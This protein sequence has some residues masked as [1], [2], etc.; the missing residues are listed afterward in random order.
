[1][2]EG[3]RFAPASTIGTEFELLSIRCSRLP[4]TSAS[5]IRIQGVSSICS[6]APVAIQ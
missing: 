6:Q 5:T 4:L 2:Q 1:V 3:S